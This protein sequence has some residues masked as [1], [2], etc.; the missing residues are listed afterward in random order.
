MSAD[1]KD[2]P[3]GVGSLIEELLENG[4]SSLLDDKYVRSALLAWLAEAG[5]RAP[6][7]HVLLYSLKKLA[8]AAESFAAETIKA[9]LVDFIQSNAKIEAA[10]R[11]IADLQSANRDKNAVKAA[12]LAD[13]T[14]SPDAAAVKADMTT[15]LEVVTAL[16]TRKTL[17]G[18]DE[19]LASL[20]DEIAATLETVLRD[21]TEPQLL[22]A[23]AG[24]NW[25]RS[26]R[27]DSVLE[28]LTYTSGLYGF[29][30]REDEL[31]LLGNFLS[32]IDSA[33]AMNRFSW[34]LLTGPGGEGKSRLALEFCK[35]H[36]RAPWHAGK[37]GFDELQALVSGPFN[38]RP[39]R[40]TL[41]V[42]D[43]PAQAPEAVNKLLRMLDR[44]WQ[45]FDLPVRVLL[46]ERDIQ[47]EWFK[48]FLG[49]DSAS[50]G[51]LDHVFGNMREGYPVPPLA[52]DAI[53]TLMQER[54][55]KAGME[56][57]P[58]E[59]L[60]YAAWK[61]DSRVRETD[62]G[63]IPLPPRAL[64]ASAV[65]ETLI[66]AQR[67]GQTE[68]DAVIEGLDRNEVLEG[69]IRRDRLTR[70][71]PACNKDSVKLE[72]HENLLAFATMGLGLARSVLNRPGARALRGDI[73]PQNPDSSVLA[74]MG[75]DEPSSRIS[76]VEPDI[77][78]EH[79]VLSR[80]E[81]LQKAG[82]SQSLIDAAF[83]LGRDEFVRFCLRCL[84]DFPER[85]KAVGLL[86][87][88]ETIGLE[89]ARLFATLWVNV[90]YSH[91]DQL[92]CSERDH[93][94]IQLKQFHGRY[95]I[96][97]TLTLREA[98]AAVNVTYHAG[99]SG[100]WLSVDA[101]L[102]RL[103]ILCSVFPD[104]AE[105]AL[106]YAKTVFNVI[107]DGCA[108]S[109]WTR[110]DAMFDRLD[111]LRLSFPNRAEI[112]LEDAKAAFN[113]IVVTGAAHDWVRVDAMFTRLGTLRTAFPEDAQIAIRD[114]MAAFNVTIEAAEESDWARTD[115]MFDRLNILRMSFPD[116]PEI[117][118]KGVMAA[119]NVTSIAGSAGDWTRVELIYDRI[120]RLNFSVGFEEKILGISGQA[121]AMR[122]FTYRRAGHLPE[123]GDS[124]E[125]AAGAMALIDW[126]I[127]KDSRTGVG[128]C[129]QVIKD[130][131]NRF[132]DDE[133]SATIYRQLEEMGMDWDQ[134]PDIEPS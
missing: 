72:L 90:S 50:L 108:A 23:G 84:N 96:D 5:C 4:L 19:K 113:V 101:I 27:T 93:F 117:A 122:Y 114:A 43:Y 40:P 35:N 9:K 127:Q 132:P 120:K 71:R 118:P 3:E 41:F 125:A 123:I 24:G 25:E 53:I 119:V 34:L 134:V 133:D 131:H 81:A 57:P 130:V 21:M 48:Q 83:C 100:D 61:I 39:R 29:H 11:R 88:S 129:L 37:L 45:K 126:S 31:A 51:L 52:P 55:E 14:Q 67:Q 99:A 94:M 64:F 128:I 69:L 112:A 87:P 6:A 15:E 74:A 17:Q 82:L 106:E 62:Q 56:P 105:I 36:V 76:A 58:P 38:W 86:F 8:Q 30:G 49:T 78:G 1:S 124:A 20:A 2:T 73:L 28:R 32:Q 91:Y 44:D 92:D 80:L 54:F 66:E 75:S 7:N 79:F 18:L 16:H 89:G 33:P 68:L 109:D 102:N 111:A 98:K 22:T 121:I 26:G 12:L 46:L 95:W 115:V 13:L 47:G 70:W 110:V 42:I 85:T 63:A 116:H 103:D 107:T 10:L 60:L 104:H 59:A 77:L 97:T 65:A